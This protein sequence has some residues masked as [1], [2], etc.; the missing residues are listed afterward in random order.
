MV[1][2]L[3]NA[4]KAGRIPHAFIL[5]GIRGVGKTTT[6]RILA[7]AVNYEDETGRHPT[8]DLAQE[9][10]HCRAIIEGRHVDVVEMDAASNTGINDIREIIDSVKYGPVSAPYKVYIIDEVHMLSTAAFNGLLKTLEEPPPYVIF[11]FATTEIR[12]VPVTILSR[13]MRFDLRRVPPETMTAHLVDIL[14]KEGIEFEPEAIA[15]IVRAGEGSVRD[16]QSL[17]DQAISHGDG[18]V[19]AATVKAM[20]GLGDRARTIDLFELL[21]RGD[22]AGALTLTRELYDAGADPQTL[23]A[24]LCDFTHLVTRIKVV[25]SAADD[26]SLTPDERSRG[27]GLAQ[28]LNMR[29]LTR[30]WQILFKGF[31]EVAAAGNA[32]QAT[33]MV[34]VRLA[35]AAD[36]PTPD[37]LALKLSGG[38]STP[39][40]VVTA[41]VTRGNGGGAV[42][43]LR[44]EAPQ[45]LYELAP[46]PQPGPTALANP[47]S[48]AELI[49]LAGQKR[50]LIVQ[51]ALKTFLRPIA[52]AD[53]RLE[54]ALVDGADPG[55]IQTLSARLKLWTGRSW[56]VS[57]GTTSELVPTVREVEAQK[58]DAEMAAA[59]EDPLVRAIL[60]TFPGS[61][62]SNVTVRQPAAQAMPDLPPL[63][64]DEDDE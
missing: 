39:V 49:E 6:A 23:V 25:P 50:D 48:Y 5:T 8:L 13:C 45:P 22:I 21:M 38:P 24:D 36:L 11:I 26:V 1:Q 60:E 64:D 54:V 37:E 15:M 17:L 27:A 16:N 40:P 34:L 3:R 12:K 14:S 56:M 35:Y 9:G 55:V 4:F 62:V 19:T 46:T 61:R 47:Q 18:K 44:A 31:D 41:P 57:V 32:L 30:T 58:K 28:Q 20:L 42:Q 10:I 7:R 52:F 59:H 51:H 53:G 63:P 43:A 29:A 2:T 33:E